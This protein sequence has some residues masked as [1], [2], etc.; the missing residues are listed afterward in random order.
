M[1][2]KFAPSNNENSLNPS[3]QNDLA[4]A[5]VKKCIK[6]LNGEIEPISTDDRVDVIVKLPLAIGVDSYK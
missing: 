2:L 6:L 4:L 1:N 3:S 5:T